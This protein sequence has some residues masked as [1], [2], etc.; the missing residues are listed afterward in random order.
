MD[1]YNR[2]KG[3]GRYPAVL[4]TGGLQDPRVPAW[5]PG[6]MAARLQADNISGKPILFRV[7]SDAG[8]GVGSTREQVDSEFADMYAFAL[9]QMGALGNN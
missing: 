6:K 2:L 1:A 4:L 5:Q 9:W 3:G 8:H 7:E